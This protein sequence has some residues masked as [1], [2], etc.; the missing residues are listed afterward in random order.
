MDKIIVLGPWQIEFWAG[1]FKKS[2]ALG[3]RIGTWDGL[4]LT[5]DWLVGYWSL[6]IWKRH[7]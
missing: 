1:F 3:F 6:E 4:C 7:G 5:L 2:I